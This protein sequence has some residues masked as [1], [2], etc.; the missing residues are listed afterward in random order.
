MGI[1]FL[2]RLGAG[3][4]A[5]LVLIAAPLTVPAGS[6]QEVRVAQEV[7]RVQTDELGMRKPAGIAFDS[8]RGELLVAGSGAD[9]MVISRMGFDEDLLG[10]FRLPQVDKPATFAV[11]PRSHRLV[12]LDG[13]ARLEVERSRSRLSGIV[14][15]RIVTPGLGRAESAAFDPNSGAWLV[16]VDG[17]IEVIDLADPTR[18]PLTIDPLAGGRVRMIATN[19]ADGLL[20]AY[21]PATGRLQALQP[22]GAVH[23]TFDLAKLEVVEPVAMT[24]APTSDPTDDPAATNLFIAD[25]GGRLASGAVTEASLSVATVATATTET[26]SLVR[27]TPTSA[28]TPGSP[29]PAGVA[30]DSATSQLVV[31]DSE[32]DEVTG[33]GWNNVNLW[34]S[35]LTGSVV[36]T[37]TMWGPN[38][39]NGGFSREPTGAGYDPAADTLFVSDDAAGRVFVLKRGADGTF[40]SSDDV[41]SS[42][43][44][45]AFGSTDTEDPTLEST[46]GH[47]FILDGTGREIYRVDP[48]DGVFGNGNDVMT[49]FDISHLG[50][51]DFEGLASA[52]GRGTLYVGA[53]STDL[54]FEI[55]L[56]GSL[57]RTIS[58]EGI[59][60]LKYIS[61]LEVAPST[62]S[63]G[64]MNFY[65]VD[66]AV[67]NGNN[68]SENDGK[69]FEVTAPDIGGPP[70]PLA[71]V[72]GNDSAA[73]SLETS[74]TIDVLDNDSDGNGDTLSVA[75]LTSPMNGTAGVVAGGVLYTPNAG[76]TGTDTFTY[77]ASDGILESNT[78]TVTVTVTGINQVPVAWDDSASTPEDTPV[79]IAVLAND[80]DGDGQ[81]LTVQLASQPASGTATVNADQTVTYSPGLDFSGSVSFTYRASDGLALSNPATVTVAVSAVNDPPVARNDVSTTAFN[82][83]ITIDVLAND[84]DVEADP[85]TVTGLSTPTFGSVV[86]VSG[87][88]QYTPNAGFVGIDTFTYRAS[89]G[90][91]ESS[92][93]TV[94]VT[95]ND[96]TAKFFAE[97]QTI[98]LGS[99]V[100]GTLA[101]TYTDDNV[102]LRFREKA[103]NKTTATWLDVRWTFVVT[104]GS[105][106]VFSLRG[107]TSG[108]AFDFAY[109]T[110]GTNWTPMTSITTTI[111]SGTEVGVPANLSGT[112]YVRAVDANRATSGDDFRDSLYID[113]MWFR[114]T[115]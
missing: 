77:R 43:N 75:G 42:I 91:L 36:G 101:S 78:A 55:G 105:S 95:V 108:E 104:P 81:P 111:E 40:G 21:V 5:F 62:V 79:V 31:V 90:V 106:M 10:T 83:P 46:T 109:S 89:D 92:P 73:T 72:A 4:S 93:A 45:S 76:F 58:L 15:T 85:L 80:N 94:T 39:A 48:V 29:D 87:V 18:V 3:I 67:D 14:T 57:I 51:T 9:A 115:P 60:G 30:W 103:H 38:A 98:L 12:A 82:T 33:A 64:T 35:T 20:Y 13:A 34:R 102:F 110:D 27:T 61:G 68:P 37:G 112:V 7:R 70:P 44:A 28:W 107:Y 6:P 32:V 113:E 24:F 59:T 63:P 23:S 25:A 52:P 16:L 74:V 54:I 47:L 8:E 41:V 96:G 86:V 50:P 49:Q 56:T 71:P 19:P 100:S 97:S 84:S 2:Q 17:A 26:A 11:D 65:V 114:S 1:R 69:L 66:R 22:N 53:R 88:V 99:L